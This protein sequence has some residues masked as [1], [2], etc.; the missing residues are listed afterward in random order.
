M[1]T[2]PLGCEV[3]DTELVIRIGLDTLKM[4]AEYHPDLCDESCEPVCVVDAKELAVDVKRELSRED[5]S[6]NTLL[7]RCLDKAIYKA[8]EDG[9]IAFGDT[10]E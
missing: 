2:I 6:G 8:W 10:E 5:D 4:A 3:T 1:P 9:S 7:S